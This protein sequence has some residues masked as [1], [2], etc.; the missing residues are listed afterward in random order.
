MSLVIVRQYAD[1][2][3]DW[4]ASLVWRN[5]ESS[6][7]ITRVRPAGAAFIGGRIYART[8]TEGLSCG[9]PVITTP[10]T[11]A[12]DLVIPGQNGEVVPIRDPA[13]IAEAVFK[14]A[15]L[16]FSPGG[17]PGISFDAEALSFGKF[18]NDF[19]VQLRSRDL[20]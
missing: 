15:D 9:L 3:I 1:L 14:W 12:S 20:A 8:V 19:L 11:G 5:P 13:A 6:R 17:K 18:E 16:I 4:M 7:E 2:A 10:N